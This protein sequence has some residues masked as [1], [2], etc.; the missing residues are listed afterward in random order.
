MVITPYLAIT[1]RKAIMFVVIQEVS[2]K[3]VPSGESKRIEVYEFSWTTDGVKMCS[4]EY[5]NS[6]ERFERPVRKAYRISIHVSYRENGKVRKKQTVICTINYYS[7]VD[8]GDWIG[9]YV[10]GGLKTK[11]DMLGLSED[12]LSDMIYEKWQPIVD[13]IWNEFKQTEEYAVRQ[14]NR[15]VINEHNQRVNAFMEKYGVGRSEYSRCYDVFGELRNPKYLEKIKAEYKA[16]KEYERKSREQRSSY[17]EKFYGNYGGY[18]G[19]SYCGTVVSNYSEDDK[20]MLK[21]F[22]RALSKAFHPDSNPDKDTSEEMKML[23]KL[24]KEWGV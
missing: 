11:A 20:V 17:Y 19:G 7:V 13:S 23:N 6:A 21:K 12:E 14:K 3:M 16:R 22:Y 9:D 10:K 24:K 18:G 4:Y 8:W 1:T 2:V 15:R 5:R